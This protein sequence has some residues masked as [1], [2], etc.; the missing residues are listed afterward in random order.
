MN[1]SKFFLID[2]N[3]IIYQSFY[4]LENMT[5]SKG[6]HTGAIFGFFR[7]LAKLYA[8][9]SPEHVM[10]AFDKSRITFRNEIYD[11]YKMH[12]PPTP[13]PLKKQMSA[14]RDILKAYDYPYIEKDGFEA[15][16]IIGSFCHGLSNTFHGEIWVVSP[17]KDLYQLLRPNVRV[18]KHFRQKFI[19]VDTPAFE[20]KY[21]IAP[22]QMIDYLALVGDSSDNIP[23]A[24][25]IGPKGAATLLQQFENIGNIYNHLD[26]VKSAALMKKLEASKENVLLSQKLATIDVHMEFSFEALEQWKLTACNPDYKQLTEYFQQYELFSLMKGFPEQRKELPLL[27]L[28]KR[29]PSALPAYYSLSYSDVSSSISLFDGKDAYLVNWQDAADLFQEDAVCAI[30]DAKAFIKLARHNHLSVLPQLLDLRMSEHLCASHINQLQMN[31]I[32]LKYLN[33]E[34]PESL[35]SGGSSS[36][37]GKKKM[38]MQSSLFQ[39]IDPQIQCQW[40]WAAYYAGEKLLDKLAELNLADYYWKMEYPLMAVL[41]EIENAGVLLDVYAMK[42]LLTQMQETIS[43]LTNKIYEMAGHS[44]N[45]NSPKQLGTI[46]FDELGL[47]VQKK[48]KTGYSTDVSVL[49]TLSRDHPLPA[50]IL[51]YRHLEKIVGTYLQ[52]LLQLAANGDGRIHTTFHQDVTATGRLSSS[53][54]NMQNIPIRGTWGEEI[55]RMFIAPEQMQMIAVDYSQIELRVIAHLAKDPNMTHYFNDELD[56]HTMTAAK[57]FQCSS[58]EIDREMRSV[59]KAV[60]F[61]LIYGKTPYGLSKEL[62]ISPSDAKKFIDR[63]FTEFSGVKKYIDNAVEQALDDGFVKTLFGRIRLI[64]E[65]KAQNKNLVEAGKRQAINT[66]VQGTASEIIKMAMINLIPALKKI[67][68]GIRMILQVHDELLFEVPEQCVDQAKQLIVD[69]MEQV[70]KLNVPLKVSLEA[71]HCW[72]K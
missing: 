68:P 10:I 13:K 30:Y 23:G 9:Y 55:R 4:A 57:I 72:S 8:T 43:S 50:K 60:N 1:S 31:Q 40:A 69:S 71:S 65:L 58:D 53:D 27:K 56:V 17:D 48:T 52:P 47:P 29:K 7:F 22:S 24:K 46:L 63:Y 32:A 66:I 3:A 67:H 25:G 51:E 33:V 5:N 37:K 61:G 42:K 26:Q 36:P 21:G 15:D 62:K 18:L 11:Q 16:D 34:L 38:M 12:R 45:I 19:E 2:G 35:F 44:F 20:N 64:P 39:S 49:E 14:I 59:A 6:E 41:E 70:V 54:P 28:K